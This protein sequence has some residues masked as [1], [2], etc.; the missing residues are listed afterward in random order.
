MLVR[1]GGEE[2]SFVDKSFCLKSNSE[3]LCKI[4]ED[5]ETG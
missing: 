3:Y 1:W 4:L 5:L 2:V